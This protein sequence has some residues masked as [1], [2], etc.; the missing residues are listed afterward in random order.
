MND[1][2]HRP[3]DRACRAKLSEIAAETP[4]SIRGTVA[5]AALQK[6]CFH[7]ADFFRDV[8]HHGCVSGM[9]SDLATYV[10]THRFFD[11]HYDEIDDMRQTF[12][13]NTGEPLKISGDLKN[14]LAW[15]AFEQVA[16]QMAEEL[17]L[18]L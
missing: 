6:T 18:G 4:T 9:I 15:F 17:E 8:C 2:T 11:T 10:D 3:S 16:F 7:V 13:A 12:E 14:A 5:N 1:P